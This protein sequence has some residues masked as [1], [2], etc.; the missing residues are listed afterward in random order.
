MVENLCC[1]I[2]TVGA[3]HGVMIAV[4]GELTITIAILIHIKL[5]N[6][7]LSIG[8]LNNCLQ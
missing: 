1:R 7:K 2:V 5:D 4:G 6:L 8:K 3:V